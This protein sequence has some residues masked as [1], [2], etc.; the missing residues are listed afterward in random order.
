MNKSRWSVAVVFAVVVVLV[1]LIGLV[2]LLVLAGLWGR[3][4]GMGWG[5]GGMMGGRCPWCGGTGVVG[6][7]AALVPLFFL[8]VLF[9]LGLF[10][11]LIGGLVWIVRRR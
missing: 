6:P 5:Q 1:L 11:L 4:G 9:G 2:L 7:R 3:L 8:L 10:L